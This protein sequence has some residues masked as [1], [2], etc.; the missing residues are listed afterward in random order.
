VRWSCVCGEKEGKKKK[1]KVPTR[2]AKQ[3]RKHK[4]RRDSGICSSANGGGVAFG[5][6]QLSDNCLSQKKKKMPRVFCNSVVC[7]GVGRVGGVGGVCVCCVVLRNDVQ[8]AKTER[9]EE[10]EQRTRS[11]HCT[12]QSVGCATLTFPADKN[13]QAQPSPIDLASNMR[14]SCSAII[15]ADQRTLVDPSV[16]GFCLGRRS[17]GPSRNTLCASDKSQVHPLLGK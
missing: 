10:R 3:R 6:C 14:L 15:S 17:L 1:A 11:L 12:V 2:A 5:C 16:Y 9:Y 8:S 7:K 4:S 13:K